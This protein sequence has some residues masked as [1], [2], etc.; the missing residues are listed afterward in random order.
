MMNFI[1]TFKNKKNEL[2]LNVSVINSRIMMHICM[3][4]SLKDIF[5]FRQFKYNK[6]VKQTKD[7][8]KKE[9]MFWPNSDIELSLLI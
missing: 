6:Y 8:N 5:M 1:V 7:I 4:I 9:K 2:L 3:Y